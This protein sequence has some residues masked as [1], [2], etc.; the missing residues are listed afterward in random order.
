[1]EG[2]HNFEI[3]LTQVAPGRYRSEALNPPTGQPVGTEF[4]LPFDPAAYAEAVVALRTT[5]SS[6]RQA[7]AAGDSSGALLREFGAALYGAALGGDVATCLRESLRAAQNAAGLRILVRLNET[8]EL[9]NVPW[10]FL[11]DGKDFL[12]LGSR[13]PV[14]RHFDN[15][16]TSAPRPIGAK[17]RILVM[18]SSPN[19]PMFPKL[20]VEA[21]YRRIEGALS[22]L[23]RRGLVDVYKVEKATLTELQRTLRTGDF[24]I[25]HFIGH[26]DF[27]RDTQEGVLILEDSDENADR[28]TGSEIGMYLQGGRSVRLAVLNA[29]EGGFTS[30]GDPFGGVAQ[31]LVRRGLPAVVAM[32]F[33]ISDQA[34]NTF[35]REFY[36]ALATG[37]PV[38]AA[39]TEAR[40]AI[41][42][43]RNRVE[44]GT[45]VLY[46]QS[47][48]GRIFDIERGAGAAAG[49]FRAAPRVKAD[50]QQA[51]LVVERGQ[52][53][54]EPIFAPG[55]LAVGNYAVLLQSAYAGGETQIGMGCHLHG[56]LISVRPVR[57]EADT[58]VA[59]DVVIEGSDLGADDLALTIS[60][61]C[62][63]AGSV[64]TAGVVRIGPECKV[65]AVRGG[66]VELG[67]A[68]QVDAIYAGRA[69]RM[70][71]KCRVGTVRGQDVTLGRD[72]RAD[73][74]Q[75]DGDLTLEGGCVVGRCQVGGRLILR[76]EP[77]SAIEIDG[78]DALTAAGLVWPADLRLAL[79]SGW[80]DD[81]N[82]FSWAG[83]ELAPLTADRSNVTQPALITTLL[84]HRLAGQIQ[85]L[86]GLHPR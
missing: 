6:A 68:C 13:T 40:R 43:E 63:I 54:E 85:P 60:G 20:D 26:G 57:I 19:D 86:A 16:A 3:T 29:C 78:Q 84:D 48:D 66:A 46:M 39:L 67:E 38:D 9:I 59:G 65:A 36:D 35:S 52:R 61:G 25:F 30:A 4:E 72:G 14:V 18:I 83:G 70:G 77:G 42:G 79:R 71:E 10:E 56:H 37:D 2:Y 27:D 24:H 12:A 51:E 53:V 41:Y 73:F 82:L 33:V 69:V 80:P 23:R 21:E 47:E 11:H 55:K 28:V 44:W 17:L 45:P 76:G 31:S 74:I 49:P 64:L 75:A 32:Q 81:A 34:A 50:L 22:D 1:M 15:V 8:P 62:E 7:S 58:V 5:R